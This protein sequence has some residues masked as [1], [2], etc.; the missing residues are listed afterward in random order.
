MRE[1]PEGQTPET[2]TDIPGTDQNVG[3]EPVPD[4]K[5]DAEPV[6]AEVVDLPPPVHENEEIQRLRAQL[7]EAGVRLRTVSKAY[8]DLQEEMDAF[9]K[10]Q[11]V[12]AEQRAEKKAAQAVERFFEPVQNLKRAVDAPGT[13]DDLRNGMRMV[14]GQFHRQLEDLGLRQIP[15]EGALFDPHLHDAL[16]VMPVTDRAQDGRI[17]AVH[18]TGWVIGDKV[19]Q[20]AQVV[21]G[22]YEEAGE[23]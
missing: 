20:P 15:G 12:L 9:R 13:A 22:K 19:I 18:A 23:A 6:Y 5:A 14:L 21:I 17:V 1:T 4:A 3:G 16:A 2:A 8:K 10:R 11:Q 7:E